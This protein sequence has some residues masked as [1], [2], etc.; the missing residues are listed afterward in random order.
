[1]IRYA[2]RD[3]VLHGEHVVQVTIVL[4]RPQMIAVR[5][6]DQLDLNANATFGTAYTALENGAHVQRAADFAQVL[7]ATL[8]NVNA[9]VR[10]ATRSS[11]SCA[12]ALMIPPT[13]LEGALGGWALQY[14]PAAWSRQA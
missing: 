13:C 7:V 4:R 9:E 10:P 5:S 6:I 2:L 11:G 8:E 1:M 3:L 14:C 12:S